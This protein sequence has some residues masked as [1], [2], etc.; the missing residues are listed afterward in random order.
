MKSFNDALHELLTAGYSEVNVDLLRSRF[1]RH[2]R[3][4]ENELAATRPSSGYRNTDR[5]HLVA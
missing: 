2:P 4:S 1:S 5:F 3:K